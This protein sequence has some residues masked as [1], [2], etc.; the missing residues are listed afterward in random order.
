MINFNALNVTRISIT[1][2]KPNKKSH[3]RYYDINK[4]VLKYIYYFIYDWLFISDFYNFLIIV[5][6]ILYIYRCDKVVFQHQSLMILTFNDVKSV[7][8]WYEIID[9]SITNLNHDK[10]RNNYSALYARV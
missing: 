5:E 9:R 7:N 6:C 10:D 4:V 1:S 8:K 2:P 3:S